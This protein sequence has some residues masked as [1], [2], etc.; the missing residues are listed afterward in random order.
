MIVHWIILPWQKHYIGDSDGSELPNH[1]IQSP[2]AAPEPEFRGRGRRLCTE[3]RL[4]RQKEEKGYHRVDID[5]SGE[6]AEVV[7]ALPRWW[8]QIGVAR[9]V[10]RGRAAVRRRRVLRHGGGARGDGRRPPAEERWQSA[11][12]RREGSSAE[13][14][15]RRRS[16][17]GR[18]PLQSVSG[19]ARRN[20]QRR[21]G[22]GCYDSVFQFLFLI[23][24]KKKRIFCWFIFILFLLYFNFFNSFWVVWFLPDWKIG[25]IFVRGLCAKRKLCLLPFGLFTFSP[26]VLLLIIVVHHLIIIY[27]SSY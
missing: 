7:A 27:Y 14:W 1:Y 9:R 24:Y 26:F 3:D 22:L 23:F 19:L 15:R 12:C 11:V 17:G 2:V 6:T 21:S 8:H 18:E 13:S 16:T 5:C 25:I 20:L 10:S 4:R